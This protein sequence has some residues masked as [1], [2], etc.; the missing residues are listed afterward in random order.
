MPSHH[1]VVGDGLTAAEFATTREVEPNDSITVIGPEIHNLGRGIAYAKAPTDASWRYAYLLN[2]PSR[3]VDPEFSDWL[4]A[5][6]A[7]V[8]ECMSGRSPDW[9]GAGE[10][11]IN[12]GDVVSLNAP[13]EIYGDFAHNRTMTKLAA[14]RSRGVRIQL[15]QTSV[16]DIEP[17]IVGSKSGLTSNEPSDPCIKVTTEDGQHLYA[18]TVDVATGGPQ[19]QQFEGDDDQCSFPALFGNEE[20]IADRLQ[21]GGSVICVGAGA[22]MLD[23]LR[24]CQSIQ[25]E[26]IIDFTALSPSGCLFPALV[27]TN[28]FKPTDYE[29]TG[30]FAYAEDFLN[31]V[32]SAQQKALNDGDS[33]YATRVGMRNL[34]AKKSLN[35]F[36]PNLSEARKVS[37]PLFNHFQGGTRDSINDFNRLMQTGNTRLVAGRVKHIE[38]RNDTATVHMTNSAGQPE[39]LSASVVVNCAGPGNQNRF[40][41]LTS[42][43]LNRGWISVCDASGGVLVGNN[44]QTTVDGVRYLG[45]AVTSIGDKVEAVP[46]YD[47]SRLRAAVQRFNK[48]QYDHK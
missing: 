20:Q 8:V 34:F 6:W 33:F 46:L 24:F 39:Q 44:G 12:T 26:A 30:T 13:R 3:S 28:N 16:K 25:S 43:M 4:P 48:C 21:T 7:S 42:A 35:D 14:L 32:K 22:S 15:L 31:A 17:E 47:A 19:N 40:D 38:Q 37:V 23:C 36:V 45:P 1:I 18:H 27:P 29:L 10:Q 5:N 9:L 41:T 11:Y 2:S